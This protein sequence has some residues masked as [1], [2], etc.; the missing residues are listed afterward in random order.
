MSK[1]LLS[2]IQKAGILKMHQLL[3]LGFEQAKS[4]ISDATNEEVISEYI[5]EGM[6]AI[7]NDPKLGKNFRLFSVSP[8][9]PLSSPGRSGKSRRK[10]DIYIER[11]GSY[12]R[13]QYHLEAKR[14]KRPHQTMFQYLGKDGLQCFVN[15]DYAFQH[16]FAGM[17]GYVQSDN[18][19]YWYEQLERNLASSSCKTVHGL[20][21][22]KH[23]SKR[24]DTRKST[25]DCAGGR[26]IIHHLLFPCK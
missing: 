16:K 2:V 14:L 23:L 19:N 17:L 5:V 8:E 3:E 12:P 9:R 7:T 18:I 15:G 11:S 26:M 4:K 22:S 10:I 24:Y 13:K 25:H 1:S 20:T 6:E 21:R